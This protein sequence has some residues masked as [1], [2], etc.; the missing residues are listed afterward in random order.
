M[1][2]TETDRIA[3]LLALLAT[4]KGFRPAHPLRPDV[5]L[6]DEMWVAA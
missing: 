2:I 6:E 3:R 5:V 1:K 4:V